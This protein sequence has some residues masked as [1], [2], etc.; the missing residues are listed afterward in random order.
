MLI[1]LLD[2][3]MP[4]P[5]GCLHK[6][7]EGVESGEPGGW[8]VG[9]ALSHLESSST[10]ITASWLPLL[11]KVLKVSESVSLPKQL[12]RR[13]STFSFCEDHVFVSLRRRA[14]PPAAASTAAQLKKVTLPPAVLHWDSWGPCSRKTWPLPEAS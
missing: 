9:T 4:G 3:V 14:F 13:P 1:K 11:V 10:H 6:G 2:Q 5:H 7:R 8:A 12:E